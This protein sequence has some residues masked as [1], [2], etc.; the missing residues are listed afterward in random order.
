MP[1]LRLR[2]R[3]A[4]TELALLLCQLGLK[5]GVTI[6]MRHNGVHGPASRDKTMSRGLEKA[7]SSPRLA[8]AR[9]LF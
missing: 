9:F 1:L 4:P 6:H 3:F 8:K 7:M 2:L 5:W